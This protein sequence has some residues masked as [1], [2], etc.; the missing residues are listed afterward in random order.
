MRDIQ[1]YWGQIQGLC[2]DLI[3][4]SIAKTIS[5]NKSFCVYLSTTWTDSTINQKV[6]ISKLT[7]TGDKDIDIDTMQWRLNTLGRHWIDR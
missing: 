1:E 2:V 4:K 3:N 6:L 5:V 7:V